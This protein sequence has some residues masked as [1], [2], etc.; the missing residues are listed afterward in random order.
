M[1]ESPCKLGRLNNSEIGPSENKI[2]DPKGP[3][4][5]VLK[6]M[7][8]FNCER[9]DFPH[10]SRKM[11]GAPRGLLYVCCKEPLSEAYAK[12]LSPRVKYGRMREFYRHPMMIR[13]CC[14]RMKLSPGARLV[15]LAEMLW[16]GF[17]RLP[18]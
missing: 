6:L 18:S 14:S 7:G 9:A 12:T 4:L 13:G 17:T 11:R 2:Q 10:R 3:L 5:P 1:F 8:G 16:R 15:Y